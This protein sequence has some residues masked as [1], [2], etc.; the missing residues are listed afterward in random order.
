MS[1]YNKSKKAPVQH[2]CCTGAYFVLI[3]EAKKP[4]FSISAELGLQKKSVGKPQTGYFSRAC[5][6]LDHKNFG[7]TAPARRLFSGS[8]SLFLIFF[9]RARPPLQ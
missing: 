7:G 1:C 4:Q 2:L 9:G 3:S 5:L 8:G 6:G